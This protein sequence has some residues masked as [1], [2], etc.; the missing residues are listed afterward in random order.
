[1]KSWHPNF[2]EIGKLIGFNQCFFQNLKPKH[3]EQEFL[4]QPQ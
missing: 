3:T 4:Q 1:V 2:V